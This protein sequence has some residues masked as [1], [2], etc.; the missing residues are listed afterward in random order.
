MRVRLLFSIFWALAA[1]AMAMVKTMV[2]ACPSFHRFLHRSKK[3]SHGKVSEC[4]AQPRG[5]LSGWTGLTYLAMRK[6][7]PS[8]YA[9][10]GVL[11]GRADIFGMFRH[12][13]GPFLFWPKSASG[14]IH[15]DGR[16]DSLPYLLFVQCSES[17]L[18][19]CPLCGHFSEPQGVQRRSNGSH[20]C[21]C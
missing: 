8:I 16:W 3:S 6:E 7:I 10:A 11:G 13:A 5:R 19:I 20:R 1:S 14:V 18:R 4:P 17:A 12:R 9:P 2:F 21:V 15:P